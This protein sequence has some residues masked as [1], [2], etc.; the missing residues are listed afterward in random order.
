MVGEQLQP[1]RENS[2]GA[3]G[4]ILLVGNYRPVRAL[5][6][7]TLSMMGYTVLGCATLSEAESL[8]QKD[9]PPGLILFDEMEASEEALAQRVHQL[10]AL[11]PSAA[12]CSLL[13]LS[14]LHPTPRPQALPGAV[15]VVAKPFNLAQVLQAVTTS[16]EQPSA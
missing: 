13:I 10:R 8:L 16:L 1:R 15:Q 5:L 6:T 11:L 14:A 9:A 3:H 7:Q 2:T 12:R 4:W